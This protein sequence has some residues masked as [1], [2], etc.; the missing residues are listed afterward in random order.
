MLLVQQLSEKTCV[1]LSKTMIARVDWLS[2]HGNSIMRP[3][4]MLI[5]REWGILYIHSAYSAEKIN[6]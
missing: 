6:R 1:K 3:Y 5:T 2:L 4:N